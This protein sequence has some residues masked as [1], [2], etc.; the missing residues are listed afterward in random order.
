MHWDENTPISVENLN[1]MENRIAQALQNIESGKGAIAAAIQ[2]MGQ[3][4]SGS[5]TFAQLSSKIRD[6]SKDADAAAGEVLSGKT[7]YS[8]GVKRIGTIPNR[9]GHVNAQSIGRN[10]TTLRLR[11]PAGY[12]PG[13]SDNSVQYNDPNFVQSNIRKGVSLFGLSGT[14][15]GHIIK[16]IN[17]GTLTITS[18]DIYDIPLPQSIDVSKCV[19]RVYY[20]P[21]WTSTTPQRRE[22]F[23]DA[24]ISSGKLMLNIGR[25][26]D[27]PI[28]LTW[29]VIEFGDDVA[30]QSG[31][32]YGEQTSLNITISPVDP[33]KSLLFYNYR[34]G[35]SDINNAGFGFIKGQFESNNMI[36]FEMLLGFC[37]IS[38]FV[39]TLP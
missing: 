28:A 8:G 3:Q 16:S 23:V 33:Y 26:F 10:G 14:Y 2:A 13:T 34:W 38:W 15:A 39:V 11:P 6:I 12:Y 7:F 22:V 5:D 31:R 17:R 25:Y 37:S 32:W 29:E 19:V 30:V 24:Y 1:N 36:N 21:L 9:S 4:A 20:R 18:D 35:Y 27:L